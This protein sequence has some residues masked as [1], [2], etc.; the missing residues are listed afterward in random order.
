LKYDPIQNLLVNLSG[1]KPSYEAAL[2]A[3]YLRVKLIERGEKLSFESVMSHSSKLEVFDLA[4]KHG[5][6]VYLYFIC[7]ESPE[8]NID[9][10]KQRVLEGGHHVDDD[11]I[12]KRYYLTLNL[13]KEAVR[14]TYRSFLWD[15]S[16]TESELILE[17]E[18]GSNITM[19]TENTTPHWC[20]QYLLAGSQPSIDK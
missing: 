14:K 3:D 4:A 10:V 2:I 15:N 18:G 20:E 1:E 12:E 7:T 19:I 11:K 8:I 13:L 9:R 6:K 5:Y 16:G 17:V